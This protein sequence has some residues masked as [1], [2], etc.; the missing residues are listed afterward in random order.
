MLHHLPVF[1]QLRHL[2]LNIKVKSACTSHLLIRF[3]EHFPK[4]ESLHFAQ[5]D[6]QHCVV[7]IFM[8]HIINESFYFVK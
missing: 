5:V 8:L 7:T 2:E 1:Q 4:L 6:K 3:L